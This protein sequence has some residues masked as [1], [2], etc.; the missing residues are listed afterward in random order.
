VIA[1]DNLGT[2]Y[3]NGAGVAQDSGEAAR[4]YRLAAEHGLANAQ[5]NLGVSYCL[6]AGV[7]QDSAEAARWLHLAADQGHEGALAAV[8]Q[9]GL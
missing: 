2:C 8:A 7:L 1:Q 5:Y 9:L 3:E 4:W 6:G